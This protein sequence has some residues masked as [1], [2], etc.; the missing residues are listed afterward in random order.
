VSSHSNSSSWKRKRVRLSLESHSVSSAGNAV[1]REASLIS[2]ANT[3]SAQNVQP[4]TGLVT[5]LP[6]KLEGNLDSDANETSSVMLIDS[7]DQ[8][9]DKEE[10][11][12]VGKE[13]IVDSFTPNNRSIKRIQ[14]K[15]ARSRFRNN[16]FQRTDHKQSQSHE[17]D[18]TRT[19]K[20]E[21]A[22]SVDGSLIR[23]FSGKTDVGMAD[24]LLVIQDEGD[25][26]NNSAEHL[27]WD[28]SGLDENE[29]D[30]YYNDSSM[31]RIINL[32]IHFRILEMR[33]IWH[34]FDVIV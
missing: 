10:L 11:K 12:D 27:K 5:Y 29:A 22:Y 24:D 20:D 16:T 21:P 23:S 17:F 28:E 18:E 34:Y 33:K 3:K 2:S 8:L 7:D 14:N 25:Q 9:D 26:S 15:V 13:L 6:V 1:A 19:V 4:K 31:V 32:I 30:E